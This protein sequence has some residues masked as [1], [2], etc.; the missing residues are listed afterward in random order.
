MVGDVYGGGNVILQS[1]IFV[2]NRSTK[3]TL[4]YWIMW[5]LRIM[6]ELTKYLGIAAVNF[7]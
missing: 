7:F 3:T 2:S 4:T 6:R 1:G 5:Q